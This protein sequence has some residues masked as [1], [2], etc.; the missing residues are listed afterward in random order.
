[1]ADIQEKVDDISQVTVSSKVLSNIIGVSDRRI[2][3]L[4][5]EGVLTKSSQGRYLLG[6]SLHGYILMLKIENDA[7]SID[8]S[9]GDAPDLE[10]EKAYHERAKRFMSELRLK[11][12]KGELHEANDIRLVMTDM[13]AKFKAKA[14]GIPSKVAPILENKDKTFI[15]S[16]MRTEISTLLIDLADYSPKDFYGEEFMDM[17]DDE[18]DENGI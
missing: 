5:E 3:Q 10:E 8:Y 9:D 14:L 17:N 2:R 4:A 13:L 16:Y 15:M 18:E 1:M 11:K 7:K 6:E 12:M